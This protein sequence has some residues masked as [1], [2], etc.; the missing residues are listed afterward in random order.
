MLGGR[1][2]IENGR[3]VGVEVERGGRT[4]IVRARREVILSASSINTPKML[5]LSGIGPAAHL[6][7]HGIDIAG[8]TRPVRVFAGSAREAARGFPANL[9]VGAGGEQV[10]QGNQ[11]IPF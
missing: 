2:V 4:E 5:M 6:A 1:V 8:A 10:I 3:A 9:N 7:E 11:W